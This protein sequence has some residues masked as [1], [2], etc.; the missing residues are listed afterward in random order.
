MF[1]LGSPRRKIYTNW[2]FFWLFSFKQELQAA[3]FPLIG[4]YSGK[5]LMKSAD[6][7]AVICCF[8]LT[9]LFYTF[10]IHIEIYLKLQWAQLFFSLPK[11][12]WKTFFW[13]NKAGHPLNIFGLVFL[14]VTLGNR[15]EKAKEPYATIFRSEKTVMFRLGLIVR[16]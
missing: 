6:E 8:M 16:L 2:K 10:Q 3:S 1:F 7:L 12:I 4:D 13:P 5:A 15:I 9:K 11:T 14:F